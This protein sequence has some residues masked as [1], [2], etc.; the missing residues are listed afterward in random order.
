MMYLMRRLVAA[1]VVPIGV[2]GVIAP[3]RATVGG[4][5]ATRAYPHMAAVES[6]GSFICGGSLVSPDQVLT[7]A[8]C[9]A[10]APTA[11]R[12]T[13]GLG[14]NDRTA[15]PERLQVVSVT[16]HESY[17]ASSARN[18]VALL[19]LAMPSG[20]PPIALLDP[21]QRERWRPGTSARVTGW[22]TKFNPDLLGLTATTF[23]Q[24][25]D[26]PVVDDAT[27]RENNASFDG[28]SQLCAGLR[29]GGKDACQGDSGGPM[30]VPGDRGQDVLVGVVSSGLG[31]GAAESYGVYSRVADQP[32]YDW[33]TTRLPRAAAVVAKVAP[34][35]SAY[36]VC[37]YRANKKSSKASRAKA[38]RACVR[39]FPK[40]R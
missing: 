15:E 30:T 35:K 36:R 7:A 9:V 26:V 2:L 27:C 6:D 5:P 40:R 20:Q 16:V 12:Y 8:H 31:C 17:G 4:Q 28:V 22:G 39:R 24:E 19:K 10:D 37:I 11:S 33:V 38:R 18:D 1:V 3:A 23:L 34:R 29:G 13:V 32:L 14:S 25:V 21:A